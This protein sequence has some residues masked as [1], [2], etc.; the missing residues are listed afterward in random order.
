MRL[1]S[2]RNR[3]DLHR[4]QID[5][6]ERL[7]QLAAQCTTIAEYKQAA[8]AEDPSGGLDWAEELDRYEN[9]RALHADLHQIDQ[10]RACEQSIE[11]IT[12]STDPSDRIAALNAVSKKTMPKTLASLERPSVAS[13]III[14]L[15]QWTTETEPSGLR[16]AIQGDWRRMQQLSPGCTWQT[17]FQ[18]PDVVQ[19]FPFAAT[20]YGRLGELF[21][22]AI[23]EDSC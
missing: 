17:L 19:H 4:H 2:A 5:Q 1:K 22:Q 12:A 13:R 7:L 8:T 9:T 11:A 18:R 16:Q 10:A 6:Y 21:A 3:P 23:S 14:A 20:G 15:L